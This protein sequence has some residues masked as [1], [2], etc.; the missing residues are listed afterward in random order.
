MGVGKVVIMV[1]V[2]VII[3]AKAITTANT[4]TTTTNTTATAA[5]K[6]GGAQLANEAPGMV[7]AAP[8]GP[9]RGHGGAQ[10]T[11][12]RR[13]NGD[14]RAVESRAEPEGHGLPLRVPARHHARA[15][16]PRGGHGSVQGFGVAA[17][18][19]RH[20]KLLILSAAVVISIMFSAGA[21]A[22]C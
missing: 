16:C 18:L 15:P 13:N 20:V 6:R 3:T 14:V 19:H 5:K 4:N 2:K 22:D 10:L 11:N 8:L 9:G 1:M 21:V 12:L 7:E 17:H